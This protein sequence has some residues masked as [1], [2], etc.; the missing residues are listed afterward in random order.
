[1][2]DQGDSGA[3]VEQALPAQPSFKADVDHKELFPAVTDPA[4]LATAGAPVSGAPSADALPG[5]CS[6]RDADRCREALEG[7]QMKPPPDHCPTREIVSIE[8][9]KISKEAGAFHARQ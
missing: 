7:T 6:S 3:P 1:M 8:K 9:G 2:R 4:A 5:R